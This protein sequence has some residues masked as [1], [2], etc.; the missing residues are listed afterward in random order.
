MSDI[1]GRTEVRFRDFVRVTHRFRID[2]DSLALRRNEFDATIGS[3]QTYLEVGYLR[4]DRDIDGGIEDLQ[5]REELR[6]AGRALFAKYWS[7]FGSG[8]INLTDAEED[9]T[10]SSD[11]FQP[12]RTRL[13]VAYEDDCLEVGLTWRRDYVTAG[14]ARRGNTFQVFFAL[15]NIGF[16]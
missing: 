2:K 1:V 4:L 14:D 5:D 3:T 13:G 9:P 7:V 6:L 11:G 10:L 8:N 12:I 16:R 15:K